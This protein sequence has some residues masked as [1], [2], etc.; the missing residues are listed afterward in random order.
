MSDKME[1]ISKRT[2]RDKI[3]S[4]LMNEAE[5]KHSDKFEIPFSRNE[6]AD[7]LCVE[8]SAMSRELSKMQRDGLI[9]FTK[10]HFE[11]SDAVSR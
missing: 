6:L 1:I 7:Y 10:K 3:L 11:L 8:R 5:K 9:R 4:Y 2:T